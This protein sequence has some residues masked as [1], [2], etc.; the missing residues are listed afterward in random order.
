MNVAPQTRERD[1][2][3]RKLR[4]EIALLQ[5]QLRASLETSASLAQVRELCVLVLACICVQP[6]DRDG[7]V[8]DWKK[9][10]A[11]F[12]FSHSFHISV[13]VCARA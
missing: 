13:Q 6:G 9:V 10:P 3:E 11:W 2:T 4:A 12:R 5:T 1:Q 8:Q 7:F